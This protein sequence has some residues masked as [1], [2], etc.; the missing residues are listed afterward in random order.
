MER[1]LPGK[2]VGIPGEVVPFLEVLKNAVLFAT[3]KCR[4]SR[5]LTFWLNG[6]LLKFL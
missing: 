1:K 2:K 6:K 5:K 4:N 3:G